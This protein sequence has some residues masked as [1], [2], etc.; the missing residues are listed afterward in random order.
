VREVFLNLDEVLFVPV[1]DGLGQWR[2]LLHFE[3]GGEIVLVLGAG[4]QGLEPGVGLQHLVV[5]GGM[6]QERDGRYA[7][8]R[9]LGAYLEGARKLD[10]DW[11]AGAEA[12]L[13][14]GSR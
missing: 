2:G 11:S 1:V 10:R 13:R 6:L 7:A 12:R 3:D 4:D 5:D 8:G 9:I 14:T